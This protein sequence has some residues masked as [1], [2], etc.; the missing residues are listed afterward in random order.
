[1]RHRVKT[2][3]FNRDFDHRRALEFLLVKSLIENN[4]VK[5]T[6]EKAKYIRP[7][8]EK[9]V[10]KARKG[11]DLGVRRY[12]LSKFRNDKKLV[13]KLL[14]EIS[15][16]YVG[17]PGGYLRINKFNLRSGDNAKMAVISWV[18]GNKNNGTVAKKEQPIKDKMQKN[19]PTPKKSISKKVKVKSTK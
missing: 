19:S 15:K 2:K 1:M 16:K 11:S 3:K 7:I 12:F 14:F 5:T 6:V 9:Y 13:D 4:S 17:R 10:T 8:V 18:E